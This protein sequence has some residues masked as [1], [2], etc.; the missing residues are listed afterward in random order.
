MGKR[1]KAT[2]C[3]GIASTPEGHKLAEKNAVTLYEA[4]EAV[5]IRSIIYVERPTWLEPE[6]MPQEVTV[7]ELRDV[8]DGE[9]NPYEFMFGHHNGKCC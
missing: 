3:E 4:F 8:Y 1:V 5:G 7:V 6:K 9:G 2:R